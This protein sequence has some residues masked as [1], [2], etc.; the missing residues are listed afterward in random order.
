MVTPH[1]AEEEQ[2]LEDLMKPGSPQFHE[3]LTADSL[4][5]TFNNVR[6][7]AAPLAQGIDAL[8]VR[9]LLQKL[10]TLPISY[11][12]EVS[13]PTEEVKEAVRA[14]NSTTEFSLPP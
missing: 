3:F 12:A 2:F 13:I 9:Y 10:E 5:L 1:P 14:F 7:L 4:V 11:L 6:E 8:H